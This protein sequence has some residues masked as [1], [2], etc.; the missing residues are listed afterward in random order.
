LLAATSLQTFTFGNTP[1]IGTTPAGQEL[2]LGGFSSL[3]YEGTAKNGNLRFI[4]NTDRGPNAEAVGLIRPFL[5][6]D[7]NPRI[8]RFELNPATGQLSITDQILLRDKNGHPI[9]GLPN[10]SIPEGTANTPYNDE[11][12]VDVFGNVL[13]IDR[14]G[15]DFEGIAVDKDG[16]FWMVDEYR[17]AIYHFHKN[18]RLKE[19]VV[20]VGS[21]AAAGLPAGSL[22]TEILP[23]V[24]GQR[25]QNRGFEGIAIQDGKVYAVVQSPIRNPASVGNTALNGQRNV[26]IV[27]LNPKTLAT[28]QFLYVMDNPD[29][30]GDTNT[31][32]DKIGDMTAIGNGEFLLVERDDDKI[33]ADPADK[34][35]KKVYRFSLAGATELSTLP[36]T[37]TVDRGSGP[38]QL[39]VDQ[40]T[41]A[42]LAAAGVHPI[43][44]TLH[45][46]LNMAGYNTVEKVEGLTL[47]DRNTIAVINDND[48]TVAGITID[49]KTG[50]F[51]RTAPPDAIVLGIIHLT[52]ITP[53][54]AAAATFGK[55]EIAKHQKRD[56]EWTDALLG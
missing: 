2:N 7:F 6:P 40:L 17:P 19:R 36:A 31:R 45:V 15:G 54:S 41:P 29:L 34:I 13:P 49:P 53:A 44:K 16:S 5:I 1:S 35:E 18:G 48:F 26:R 8:V 30:G 4:T 20:P 50:L 33:S 21:A 42:E 46:D 24:L 37:F 25:R 39:T 38:V 43:A 32:A 27:E 52:P 55:T 10:V 14:L 28:R 51:T 56:S 47:V 12:P 9:S 23:A 11:T 3:V 22:G